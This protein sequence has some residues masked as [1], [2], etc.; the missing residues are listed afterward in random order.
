[1]ASLLS[2]NLL[3]GI[4]QRPN[5]VTQQNLFAQINPLTQQKQSDNVFLTKPEEQ[6]V[7]TKKQRDEIISS[8]QKK[9][10]NL[11]PYTVVRSSI[12]LYSW[13]DMQNI[14]G[15]IAITN[16]DSSGIGSV[17]DPRMGVIS[18]NTPCEYC[19]KIDCPGHYGLISFGGKKIYNPAYIR[20][21]ISILTCV[22]NDC[23]GLL[24]TRD[25]MEQEG[26]LKLS[27]NKR[28]SAM[29]K[30]C[31]SLE[32]VRQKKRLEGGQ[33]APCG[34]NPTFV[35]TE[36]MR[37]GEISYKVSEKGGRRANK[38]D[39]T[40]L[41]P[42][43]SVHNILE[44][45]SK[46]D[47]TLLGFSLSHPVDLIMKGL[48]VPPIIARPPIYE[49]ANIF[50]DQLTS[51]YIQIVRK[52]QLL[53]KNGSTIDVYN[54]VKQLIFKSDGKKI[55]M[56]DFLS[57]V[58]R[59][60]G[61]TALLRGLLMGKRNNYCGRTV[62]GPNPSL[63]FGEISLPESWA[64]SLTKNEYVTSFNID[65]LTKLLAEGKIDHITPKRSGLRKYYSRK[66]N[67]R[68]QIGD[69]V[70]RWLQNGDRVVTNRQP[71]LHRQSMMGYRVVLSPE[72][73]IGYHLSYTSP[74][75]LDFDGDETNTYCPQDFEVEAEVEFLINVKHNLMSP[76][77]NRPN[78]G[79]VMNS[80]TSA[81]L[82]SD[83]NTIINDDLFAELLTLITDQN[84]LRTLYNRLVKYGVHPRSG[85]AIISA[86]LPDDFYYNQK[87]VL[88]IEGI[89]I[90]GQLKKSH[91]GSSH[92]S[93]IQ[94]LYKKYGSQRTCDFFSDASWIFN[95]W[96]IERGFSVGI[97]DM[98][99]LAIDEK[100]GQEY[101][102][103]KRVLDQ[104]LSKILVQFEALG[105]KSDDH[106][107]EM[108]RQRQINNTVNIAQ[109]IGLRLAKENFKGDNSL[110][111]MTDQG[112]GTKGSAA[113]IGQAV[114]SVG[115]QFHNG[116]RL[117]QTMSGGRRIL[118]SFDLDDN[119][120]EANGFIRESFFTGV[121]PEGFFFLQSG[122]RQNLLDTSLKTAE[123]GN[124]HHRMIK[125][126][127]NIVIGYDGSV[128]NTIGT[129]FSP[130]YNSGYDTAEMLAVDNPGKPNFSSFVDI[131]NMIKE[132]NIKRGWVQTITLNTVKNLRNNF[133][134]NHN[135]NILPTDMVKEPVVNNIPYNIKTEV[136]LTQSTYK[137]TKFEKSRTIG[138]RAIQLSN[139]ATPIVN[140][141]NL[142]D[143]VDIA[144]K[145]YNTGLLQTYVIR[146]F[147]DDS[148]QVVNLTKD[149]I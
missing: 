111:I 59:I 139:N 31:E 106:N 89:L 86:M 144:E 33:L 110:G 128:R 132:L 127:E 19:T 82:M 10:F 50:P 120:P 3:G 62:A 12:S 61:K 91:V 67:Y 118:P 25:I 68:L 99:S 93:I 125:A 142:T 24:I 40:E 75:N 53:N 90:S 122:A 45:I 114:G 56:K 15:S 71:T 84:N 27:Q 148:S 112:A 32:C 49:G 54:E 102:K 103:N 44:R 79:L 37:K 29:E 58:D 119:S 70:E 43:E 60:Q 115:Q 109:G 51:K 2:T 145:E 16:C 17:N 138:T 1:M 83:K 11:L 98:I 30:Y 140:I 52:V 124:I 18:M 36:V 42:I 76:E 149:L 135:E 130:M 9:E 133:P 146:K 41:F 134:V 96:I 85:R 131:K 28:L 97:S 108:L 38:D 22:C 4:R 137:I 141:G 6:V 95:K 123:T 100:T 5:P 69:K 136:P 13:K 65:R 7:M 74:Y 63:K 23:G 55:G 101:D 57:I 64:S 8:G 34:K 143:L 78:M 121:T 46:E 73:T 129:L 104:E 87:G 21:V 77:Q 113:N 81:Y 48:L 47:A 92:R 35:T 66:L 116:E 88:I 107:E 20:E 117:K 126:F 14:A 39:K 26:F 72:Y 105:G 147:S 94:E 80:I